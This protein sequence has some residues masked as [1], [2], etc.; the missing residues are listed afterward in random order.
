MI[1][2]W[3]TGL[4]IGT[5]FSTRMDEIDWQQN[6]HVL[7]A[8]QM[9]SRRPMIVHLT[10]P[11]IAALRS[12]RTDR[13]VIFPWPHWRWDFSR[14]FHRLQT[15]AGIL[16]NHQFGFHSISKT[17]AT[18]LYENPGAAHYSRIDHDGHLEEQT[19][20]QAGASHGFIIVRRRGAANKRGG[21]MIDDG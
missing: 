15:A 3:N 8:A 18:M 9:K 10:P 2:A 13:Q 17:V 4:R 19:D 1:V 16:P 11:V 12:I 6:R 7:A 5:L 21:F 20:Q 14:A